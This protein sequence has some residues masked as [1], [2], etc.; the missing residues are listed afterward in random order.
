MHICAPGSLP[1]VAGGRSVIRAEPIW[2]SAIPGAPLR[3]YQQTFIP[4][5]GPP[6]HPGSLTLAT[7]ACNGT[8]EFSL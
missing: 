7:P 4:I 6:G 5:A 8:H 1:T 3:G 2:R